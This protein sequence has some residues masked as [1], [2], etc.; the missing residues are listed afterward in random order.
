[1][2]FLTEQKNQLT[3]RLLEYETTMND[4]HFD[5]KGKLRLEKEVDRRQTQ[6]VEAQASG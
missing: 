2:N 4:F 6:I 5:T 1:M 3:K